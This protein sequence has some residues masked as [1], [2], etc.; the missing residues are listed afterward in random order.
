MGL[1]RQPKGQKEAVP[2][3]LR[4]VS[5]AEYFQ[6]RQPYNV[7]GLL[8]NPMVIMMGV[9]LLLVIVFPRLMANMSPEE[10][11]AMSKMS[12]TNLFK[13][14]LP[15]INPEANSAG[16]GGAA[17]GHGHAH[18]GESGHN[19]SH[20]G[21]DD[22]DIASAVDAASAQS[23]HAPDTSSKKRHKRK[24]KEIRAEELD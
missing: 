19:H 21:G 24:D 2:L 14:Q 23:A 8:K 10:K 3:A 15:N 1:G 5:Q 12:L 9:T 16:G 13:G 7:L 20:G 22:G 11:E 17:D 18:D 6:K 4:P